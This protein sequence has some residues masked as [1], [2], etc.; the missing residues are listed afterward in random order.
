MPKPATTDEILKEL[1]NEQRQAVQHGDDPLLVIAG[2]GTGKTRTLVHRVAHLIERGVDPSRILLLTFTRRSAGEMLRRVESLL[3]RLSG[4]HSALSRRVWGGTFHATAT[5]LLRKFGKAIGLD[6]AFTI[7]DRSDSEDLLDVVR[8]ELG[9]PESDK[10]FPKKRTCLAIYSHSI[11]AQSPLEQI[12]PRHFSWCEDCADQL[13]QLFDSYTDR[14]ERSGILDYDDLLLF[15]HSLMQHQSAGDRVREQFDNVL[16]DEFQD[17][18]RLQAGIVKLLR[19]DGFGVTVVGDDS[20]SIYSFRAATVRNILG[21]PEEF[22]GTKVLRLEQNYRSPQPILDVANAILEQ[23]KEGYGKRLW[24]NRKS[25]SKPWLVTCE[26]EDEQAEFLISRIL[27]LRE[28]GTD[29]RDQAVLFRASFHSMILEAELARHNIPFVKYGGMKFMEAAH[30]K[31]VLAVLHLAENPRDEVAGT[32]V[33]KLFPGIGPKT[34]RQLMRQLIDSSGCFAT[35]S[36]SKVPTA[37]GAHWGMFVNLMGWLSASEGIA[38]PAQVH[39][40]CETYLPLLEE[41]Y[42]NPGPR[43]RDLEQLEQLSAKFPD[44]LTLLAELTLDPPTSTSDFAAET[45]P[46]E[47]Y[48]IL[49]TIHSAKGLEW[50]AV[51]TICASDGNIPSSKAVN[52]PEQIEEERRLFYVALTRA[53]NSLCVTFPQ[54]SYRRDASGDPYGY[55]QLTRFITEEV[56]QLFHQQTVASN[57]SECVSDAVDVRRLAKA[58]WR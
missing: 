14:K 54:R 17:T 52:S 27:E 9:L 37:T 40:V 2:A 13:K 28:E 44:R 51:Y 29:L 34:A 47:D 43:I 36:T 10:R 20:Q 33:L 24:T 5:R 23:A 22:P 42:D 3:R 55:A 53:K 16:V 32:R 45:D 48:L 26:D 49:S 8:T 30:V 31:D 15:W 41:K 57:G 56:K 11:N 25:G 12:L 58:I 19:P 7:H 39:A 4:S 1:N 6:P 50:K 18:N 46:D 38:L 21:F 35:W